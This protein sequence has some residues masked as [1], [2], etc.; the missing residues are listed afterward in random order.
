MNSKQELEQKVFAAARVQ[1]TSAVLFRNAI[2]RKL[3]L[4][5]ADS[6]CLSFLG[7]KGTATPTELARYTGLTTGSTTAMLDRLEKSGF[8]RRR[9]NPKDRRGVIVEISPK[10][11]ETAQPFVAGVQKA[12]QEL[13]A[14]Y[15]NDELNVIADFL[16]RFAANV[17]NHTSNT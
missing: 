13:L 8:I 11:M 2:G 1:G 10:Y 6:E 16:T 3:G 15:S 5:V 17:K 12:H 4:N 7:I 9:P 14:R